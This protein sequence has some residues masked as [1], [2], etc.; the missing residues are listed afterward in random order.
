M[1]LS[2]FV[3]MSAA[4]MLAAGLILAA[5]CGSTPAG[6]GSPAA[7][8]TAPKAG[9]PTKAASGAAQAGSGAIAVKVG[10]ITPLSGDVKTYGESVKNAYE[11]AIEEA[12]K[13]GKVNITTV[14]TDSKGD[15]TEGVNAATKLINQ[16]KVKAI[17]GPVISRVAIGVSDIVNTNKI[18]MITP[19]GTAPKVTVDNGKRKEYIFR[20][21]FIDPFQGQVMAKFGLNTVK[22]KNASIVYDISNDYSKGLAETFKAAFEQGG[23]KVVN[24]ESY[25]KDDV[26][27]SAILTKVG[28]NSPDVLFLPDY[29]NKVSL[30]GRQAKEKG[31]KATLLGVDGWDSAELDAKAMEGG[32]FS[33]HYS[34]EDQRPEVQEW[35]K[36][37]QAKFGKAPDAL[38]TLAY[39]AAN[40]LVEAIVKAGSDDPTK[41]RDAMA[42]IKDFKAVT[43]TLSFDKDGNPIKSAVV[44]QIK[45]GK[46]K[47]VE[48]VNP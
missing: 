16:D 17:F 39:D 11:L 48:T 3:G 37:Y 2:R 28:S 46:Q 30:I 14:V 31:V 20:S 7:P 32:Y 29:Y 12:N 41:I 35:I 15:A 27:F 33:N 45:D 21:C 40:L 22:A 34:A 47:Y 8:T 9:E 42:N 44:L 18:V 38:G 10:M 1:Q 36:K 43:G 13:A 6:S 5:G 26:D 4:S 25:G 24:M 19:T 23:G